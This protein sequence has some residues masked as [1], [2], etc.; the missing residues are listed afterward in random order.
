[1]VTGS[2]TLLPEIRQ[3]DVY[4]S[5]GNHTDIDITAAGTLNNSN[6]DGRFSE[7]KMTAE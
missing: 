3:M 5:G 1:V 6:G 2:S 4:F 7:D